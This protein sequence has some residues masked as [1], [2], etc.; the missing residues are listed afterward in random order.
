MPHVAWHDGDAVVEVV[1]EVCEEKAGIAALED[2]TCGQV[3]DS[4]RFLHLRLHIGGEQQVGRVG[5]QHV[6]GEY[7][8]VGGPVRRRS[9][10]PRGECAP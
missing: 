9:R 5:Q 1:G 4:D 8:I 3:V 2:D 6:D 10:R 7:Q